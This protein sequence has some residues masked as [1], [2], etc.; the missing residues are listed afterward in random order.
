MAARD[1]IDLWAVHSGGRSILDVV[2]KGPELRTDP[3]AVSR[4]VLSCFGN[5]P[6]TTV[7]FVLQRRMQQG[8]PGQRGCAM[9]FGPARTAD[10]V[11]YHAV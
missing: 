6:S 4:E 11:R 3:L 10:T 5:M 7:M 9:S 8:R 1:G 2:E